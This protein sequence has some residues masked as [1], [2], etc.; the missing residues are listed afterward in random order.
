MYTLLIKFCKEMVM[1]KEKGWYDETIKEW[2]G[3]PNKFSIDIYHK[4]IAL[5]MK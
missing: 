4:C 5:W 2:L 1:H 3:L